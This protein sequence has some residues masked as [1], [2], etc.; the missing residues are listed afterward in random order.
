M[1]PIP[2][3]PEL[4]QFLKDYYDGS[5][6]ETPNTPQESH[7]ASRSPYQVQI[8][9]CK[10]LALVR[11]RIPMTQAQLAAKVGTTQSAIAR[12]ERGGGNPN[13]RLLIR[14]CQ[15]LN[16]DLNLLQYR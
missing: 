10:R 7:Q 13:L 2:S 3:D 1:E 8:D 6:K 11:L 14:I 15:Q 4:E 16:V 9:L 12:L 5:L